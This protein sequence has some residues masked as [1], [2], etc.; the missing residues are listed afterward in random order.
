MAIKLGEGFEITGYDPIDFRLVLTKEQMS[1]IV[2]DEDS[3]SNPDD[4][5]MP[6]RYFAF[7]VDDGFIYGFD[8]EADMDPETGKFRKLEL[9]GNTPAADS[10]PESERPDA[11]DANPGDKWYDPTTGETTVVEV[12]SEGNKQW[13]PLTPAAGEMMYDATNGKI[14]YF[15]GNQWREVGGLNDTAVG[16][17][18]PSNPNPGDKWLDE[19]QNPPVLKE[20]GEDGQWHNV[21]AKAGEMMYDE[22][23][24][25]ILY[26]DGNT[27]REVGGV[28][29]AAA[30]D[31]P[32][33]PAHAG[34][35]WLDTT[36]NPPVL[37]EYDGTS[38]SPVSAKK[39]DMMYDDDKDVIKYYDGTE[40]KEMGGGV[41]HVATLPASADE[42]EIIFD[43]STGQYKVYED[44]V[45]L[46]LAKTWEGTEA[47]YTTLGGNTWSTAHPDVIMFIK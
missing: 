8:Y 41:E 32:P 47:Q 43:E 20:Y 7:C 24:G 22:T 46:T 13:V 6:E 16:T 33:T 1:K 44:G 28:E 2:G 18:A 38:W 21:T 9:G 37:K 45:W 11:D 10:G 39:G 40:W 4:F 29:A 23:A 5:A 31:T 35:R 27:W 3:G 17:T 26:F 19:S 14:L 12:D 15:D 42:G 30:G 25:K 34:D 36:Q